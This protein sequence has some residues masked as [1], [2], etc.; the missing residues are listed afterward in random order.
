MRFV[1]MDETWIHHYT[2]ESKRHTAE[3]KAT[4]ESRPKRLKTQMS[5]CKVLA[6][7]FWS[8]H[9]ILY[10]N[11]FQKRRTINSK[12]YMALLVR[13]KKE[14]AKKRPRMKKKVLFYQDNAPCYK[15]IATITKLHDLHFELL[16]YSLYS[17][18][19][20]PSDYYLFTDLKKIH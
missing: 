14:I 17:L 18:D 7:I 6:S 9:D 13:L 20:A 10:V 1:N 15:S 19:M 3:W 5:A 4:G 11:C 8:A 16:H 2:L 12:Y